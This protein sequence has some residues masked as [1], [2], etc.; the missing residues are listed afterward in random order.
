MYQ[1]TLR[2]PSCSRLPEKATTLSQGSTCIGDWLL[3][4]ALAAIPVVAVYIVGAVVH[5][6]LSGSEPTRTEQK[7]RPQPGFLFGR[8]ARAMAPASEQGSTSGQS[9]VS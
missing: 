1:P 3:L 5:A 2:P 9:K 4:A 8:V 6:R 7:A